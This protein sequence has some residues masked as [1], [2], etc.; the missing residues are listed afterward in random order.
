MKTNLLVLSGLVLAVAACASHPTYGGADQKALQPQI[1][2][3]HQCLNTASVQ[4]VNGSD[5]VT[6]LTQ[7]ILRSCR[8]KLQ[9][10]VHYLQGRGFQ[11]YFI[12]NYLH[13]VRDDAGTT[14]ESFILRTKSSQNSAG[15]SAQ[16]PGSVFAA[17]SGSSGGS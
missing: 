13:N 6:L 3:Y 9:P 2:S 14:V 12:S 5:N 11:S 17:P 16:A 8:D 15:A 1:S 10:V 7:A 4:M